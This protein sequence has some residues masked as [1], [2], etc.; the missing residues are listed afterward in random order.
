MAQIL[1]TISCYRRLG[2]KDMVESCM[3]EVCSDIEL[4][5]DWITFLEV[6][7]DGDLFHYLVKSTPEHSPEKIVSVVKT[8]TVK[9]LN[10]K[11][12]EGKQTLWG[13]EFWNEGY[14]VESVGDDNTVSFDEAIKII[15]SPANVL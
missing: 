7:T 4:R 6:G 1:S 11:H 3:K 5:Y 8:A 13:G 14:A 9:G 10:A 15:V 12:P 2:M